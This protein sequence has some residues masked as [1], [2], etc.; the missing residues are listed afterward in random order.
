Q[1]ARS[2][3]DK[4]DQA[5]H[6][7]SKLTVKKQDPYEE[8]KRIEEYRRWCS[9][10]VQVNYHLATLYYETGTWEDEALRRLDIVLT[11][12]S[13]HIEALRLRAEIYMARKLWDKAI[14]DLE[15]LAL[16]LPD[17]E[18]VFLKLGMVYT[19]LGDDKKAVDSY[20]RVGNVLNPKSLEAWES[21]EKFYL[22]YDMKKD[23]NSC[24]GHIEAIKSNQ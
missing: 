16:Y 6:P 14:K 12:D 11:E 4:C 3:A 9:K 10:C 1:D 20:L 24:R 19:Q 15:L 2:A 23:V 21:L 7:L 8:R 5:L 22:K 13:G 18:T 17:D